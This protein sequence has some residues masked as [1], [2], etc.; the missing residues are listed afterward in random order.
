VLLFRLQRC[1]RDSCMRL[2]GSKGGFR[3][4]GML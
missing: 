4:K 2:P 3:R 1:T